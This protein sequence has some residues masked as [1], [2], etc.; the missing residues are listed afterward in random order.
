M[1]LGCLGT[2]RGSPVSKK[3]RGLKSVANLISG[4]NNT[5]VASVCG[6]NDFK[7]A[8]VAG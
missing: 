2:I 8:I 5:Y 3:I 6:S 4:V 7:Q 1:K